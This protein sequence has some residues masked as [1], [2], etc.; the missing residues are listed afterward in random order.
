MS[1]KDEAIIE[2]IKN[3][4]LNKAL[5]E[6]IKLNNYSDNKREIITLYG[7]FNNLQQKIRLGIISN[8][9]ER[10]E[11]NKIRYSLLKIVKISGQEHKNS[12]PY[13]GLLK[14]ID[15]GTRVEFLFSTYGE[16]SEVSYDASGK[17]LLWKLD[18]IDFEAIIENEEENEE[19]I[20]EVRFLLYHHPDSEFLLP[21]RLS[22][23]GLP[24]FGKLKFKDLEKA[25][26]EIQSSPLHG[27]I[28]AEASVCLDVWYPREYFFWGGE[29]VSAPNSYWYDNKPLTKDW[30]LAN[31]GEAKI[32]EISVKDP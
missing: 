21:P 2:H 4:D 13:Q 9:E 3:G 31:L 8:E 17:K 23:L 25:E 14:T 6:L 5:D 11:T 26:I 10:I 20:S 27:S 22:K 7:A 1:S 29:G 12:I 28:Y 30:L 15:V 32:K 18:S 16:P 24:N 19:I